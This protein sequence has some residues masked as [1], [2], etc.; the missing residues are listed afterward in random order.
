MSKILSG[1]QQARDKMIERQTENTKNYVTPEKAYE[2][3]TNE[4]KASKSAL[5]AR[6]RMIERL[7]KRGL[8]K[9]IDRSKSC[10]KRY[11]NTDGREDSLLSAA[12]R[13]I[14]EAIGSRKAQRRRESSSAQDARAA[15]IERMCK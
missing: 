1:A 4:P 9:D 11:P 13:D 3:L 8:D 12:R 10:A 5:D 7:E 14:A 6:A 15:M 2:V